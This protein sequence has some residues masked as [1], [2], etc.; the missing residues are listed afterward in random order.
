MLI[1]TVEGE[2]LILSIPQK[3]YFGLDAVGTRMWQL[4]TA[5]DSVEEAYQELLE[6][7][8]V[9]PEVLSADLG[10]FLEQLIH[11]GL[12]VADGQP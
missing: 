7:F 5:K 11:A 12:L 4:V 9:E 1:R 3:E 10:A 2:S 8:D 6:E